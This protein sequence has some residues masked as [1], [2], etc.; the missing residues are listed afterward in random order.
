MTR[1]FHK[2]WWVNCLKNEFRNEDYPSCATTNKKFCH[3]W[4]LQQVV[5]NNWKLMPSE[6]KPLYIVELMHFIIIFL[7]CH[8]PKLWSEN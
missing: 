4:V 3:Q 8:G 1:Q 7:L 5:D 2:E 6:I